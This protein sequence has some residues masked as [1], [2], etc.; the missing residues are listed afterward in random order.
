MHDDQVI[1][2]DDR[3][4]LSTDRGD[5]HPIIGISQDRDEIVYDFSTVYERLND[6]AYQEMEQQTG[7]LD[8]DRNSGVM[9]GIDDAEA[10]LALLLDETNWWRPERRI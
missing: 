10:V 9:T 6:S 4:E 1:R 8:G 5:G 2:Y 7:E 3:D